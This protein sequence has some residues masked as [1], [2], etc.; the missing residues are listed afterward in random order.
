MSYLKLVQP[1]TVTPTMLTASTVPEDDYAAWDVGT[2]YALAARVIYEHNVYESLQASNTGKTPDAQPLWWL[3]IG[4]CNRWRAFDTSPSTLTTQSASISYTIVPGT[5]CNSVVLLGLAA[6]TVRVRMT[7]VTD[8]TVYDKTQTVSGYIE[9]PDWWS[10]FFGE[11]IPQTDA[12]FLDLPTYGS[13]TIIIDIDAGAGTA[14]VG[15][16]LIGRL[17][18]LDM[19]VR[20]GAEVGIVDFSRKERDDFGDVQLVQRGFARR[21]EF[22]CLVGTSSVDQIVNTLAAVRGTPCVW[23]GTEKTKTT[24]VY[25]WYN[26]FSVQIAYP[27]ISY[28]TIEIE[29][30]V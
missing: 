30:L 11:V 8:G 28:S 27:Q 3:K 16:V 29:G 24:I 14:S 22:P 25:G 13:G 12:L 23:V 21:V 26:D 15:V 17:K 19:Q 2:T 7:D 18:V 20:Y 10:Y 1:I 9:A 4:P 6:N 5:I